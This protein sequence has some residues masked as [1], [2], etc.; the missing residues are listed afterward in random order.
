MSRCT[1]IERSYQTVKVVLISLLPYL[2]S[3]KYINKRFLFW[4]K[5]LQ[6]MP[7]HSIAPTSNPIAL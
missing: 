4:Q 3:V 7:K 5:N 1:I 6:N 2:K